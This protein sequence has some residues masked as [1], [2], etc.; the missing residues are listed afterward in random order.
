MDAKYFCTIVQQHN[1][2]YEIQIQMTKLWERK[3]FLYV[4]Y[5]LL[6]RT[7][8]CVKNKIK[9]KIMIR[10][11]KLTWHAYITFKIHYKFIIHTDC[12]EYLR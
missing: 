9:L 2:N 7:I 11:H 4:L 8:D 1:S 3:Q 12:I 10:R 6:T 5:V